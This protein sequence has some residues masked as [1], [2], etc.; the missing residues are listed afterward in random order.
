LRVYCEHTDNLFR[1]MATA[2]AIASELFET[3][4]YNCEPAKRIKIDRAISRASKKLEDEGLIH[5]PDSYTVKKRL[6][7]DF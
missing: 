4:G 2:S 6:P 7:D 1:R 5:E 3:C